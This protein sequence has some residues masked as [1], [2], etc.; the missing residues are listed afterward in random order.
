MNDTLATLMLK[1]F[2]AGLSSHAL[3]RMRLRYHVW[4][5]Y[6]LRELQKQ[7]LPSEDRYLAYQSLLA[8]EALVVAHLYVEL[9]EAES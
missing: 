4:R 2:H 3:A 5:I 7:L 6:E 1:Q 9:A 8:T